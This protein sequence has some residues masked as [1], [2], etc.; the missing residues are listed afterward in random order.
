MV[1]NQLAGMDDFDA[2]LSSFDVDSK[3][4]ANSGSAI[5]ILSAT[6]SFGINDNTPLSG[7]ADGPGNAGASAPSDI[8]S[9][10]LAQSTPAN[11]FPFSSAFE[12]TFGKGGPL[13]AF[14]TMLTSALHLSATQNQAL[15]NISIEN[16]DIVNTPDSVQK[17]AMELD[18]AGIT[19]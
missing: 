19:A 2:L 7:L 17:V 9:A 1:Q 15:Q 16:K 10:I 11:S 8:F 6:N 4:Q 18:Q 13:P 5:D 14:I 12:S 3:Q